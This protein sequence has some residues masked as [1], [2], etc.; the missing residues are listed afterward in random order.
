MNSLLVGGDT[1][2]ENKLKK[3][4]Y[5]NDLLNQMDE[6]KLR[7]AERYNMSRIE[8]ELEEERLRRERFHLDRD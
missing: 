7:R 8:N 6:N 1:M 3:T 2:D 4:L 5:R